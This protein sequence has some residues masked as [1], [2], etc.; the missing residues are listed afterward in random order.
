MNDGA[1]YLL[2]CFSTIVL[3]LVAVGFIS[4]LITHEE[5]TEDMLLSF[6]KSLENGEKVKAASHS[7]TPLQTQPSPKPTKAWVIWATISCTSP[8]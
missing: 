2:G 1:K 7:G 5:S 4:W 8:G 6:S 3:I